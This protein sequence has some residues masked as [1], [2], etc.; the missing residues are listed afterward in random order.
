MEN[1]VL[2]QICYRGAQMDSL[3]GFVT[4]SHSGTQGTWSPARC[5]LSESSKGT[6]GNQT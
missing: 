6:A 2:L 5:S 4:Y 1:S 3:A